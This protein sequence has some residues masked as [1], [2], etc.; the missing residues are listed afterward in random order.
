MEAPDGKLPMIENNFSIHT[1]IMAH[2]NAPQIEPFTF[3]N[4]LK[5]F[6]EN[7]EN[8]F[9]S[10][11]LTRELFVSHVLQMTND[12]FIDWET[13]KAFLSTDEFINVLELVFEW[14]IFRDLSEQG[15]VRVVSEGLFYRNSGNKFGAFIDVVKIEDPRWFFAEYSLLEDVVAVGI[16]T[17]DRGR[18][19]VEITP[20]LGIYAHSKNQ[21]AAWDFIRR[22]LLPN[23]SVFNSLPLR[24]DKFEAM[25]NFSM[26]T[27]TEEP[28]SSLWMPILDPVF[29]QMIPGEMRVLTEFEAA[30]LQ[31]IIDGIEDSQSSVWLLEVTEN[32]IADLREI[33]D[34]ADM[35]M[36]MFDRRLDTIVQRQIQAFIQLGLRTA[37]GFAHDMQG[38]V[39][40]YLDER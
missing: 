9:Y 25:M 37:D 20:G 29:G 36:P 30:E 40:A 31:R 19:V 2:E 28:R 11:N 14:N 35:L 5:W 24:I 32:E 17:N 15:G 12:G 18:H 34:S 26:T 39:Q 16:P 8:R 38:H 13:N 3:E 27:T 10:P 4:I 33:I 22:Y 6:Q 21:D 1:Y 7:G 23:A